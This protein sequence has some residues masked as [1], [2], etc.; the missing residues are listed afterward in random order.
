MK[1]CFWIAF[2]VLVFACFPLMLREQRYH[3]D[4]GAVREILR[5]EHIDDSDLSLTG[6]TVRVNIASPTQFDSIAGSGLLSSAAFTNSTLD[7]TGS[8]VSAGSFAIFTSFNQLSGTLAITGY[9]SSAFAASY[10]AGV[11]TFTAIPEPGIHILLFG[12]LGL[13]GSRR[14]GRPN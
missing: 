5:S 4:M 12:A 13:A 3:D 8:N 10:S 9:D 1:Y 2:M 11:V 14:R 7:F 6:T